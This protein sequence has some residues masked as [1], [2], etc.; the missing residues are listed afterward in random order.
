M[1]SKSDKNDIEIIKKKCCMELIDVGDNLPEF[2]FSQ[3]I[4]WLDISTDVPI[5]NVFNLLGVHYL[6]KDKEIYF[7]IPD[8]KSNVICKVLKINYNNQFLEL[9]KKQKSYNILYLDNFNITQELTIFMPSINDQTMQNSIKFLSNRSIL[10]ELKNFYNLY[11]KGIDC[12]TLI[13]DL[14]NNSGGKIVDLQKV[15]GYFIGN[16]KEIAKIMDK[17]NTYV[18]KSNEDR[19]IKAKRIIILINRYTASCAELLILSL[20]DNYNTNIIGEETMGKWVITMRQKFS[21]YYVKIPKF[22]IISDNQKIEI[23]NGIKP[24]FYMD[25]FMID[26]YVKNF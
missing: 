10:L 22:H 4:K 5:F 24:S 15:S 21:D 3:N 1:A 13:L 23:G 14:R 19:K 18:L 12:E 2:V 7:K 9:A 6:I 26:D 20:I 25:D 11:L 16:D 8:V 17:E